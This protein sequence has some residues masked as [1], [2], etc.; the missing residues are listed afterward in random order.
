LLGLPVSE[1]RDVIA[2]VATC[3]RRLAGDQRM[4]VGE[5]DRTPAPSAGRIATTGSSPLQSSDAAPSARSKQSCTA[6]H[7][8]ARYWAIARGTAMAP[9]ACWG[10]SPR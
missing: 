10:A 1:I 3:P 5:S 9:I 8:G 6:A 7:D 4:L 2:R